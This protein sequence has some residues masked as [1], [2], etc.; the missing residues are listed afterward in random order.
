MA[1]FRS[2]VLRNVG[3][4]NV[5]IYNEGWTS[6]VY[7][8]ILCHV[9]LITGGIGKRKHYHSRMAVKIHNPRMA[10]DL[11][12]KVRGFQKRELLLHPDFDEEMEVNMYKR[13]FQTE[14]EGQKG[15]D[16]KKARE[17]DSEEYVDV[18]R[19]MDRMNSNCQR[20]NKQFNF[21]IKNGSLCSDFTAQ[22]LQ[23]RNL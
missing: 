13:Y 1:S 16:R 10:M 14:V 6:R 5:Y 8:F 11:N 19:M 21:T 22:R 12:Y 20:C 23:N 15:Q 9:S 18:G 17:T 3:C 2:L 4:H 7:I